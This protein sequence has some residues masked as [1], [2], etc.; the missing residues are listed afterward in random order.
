MIST[1]REDAERRSE[2]CH[3][4]SALYLSPHCAQVN[5]LGW[6]RSRLKVLL[7]GVA[8]KG[9]RFTLTVESVETVEGI[10]EL[11]PRSGCQAGVRSA[12]GE[13]GAK[14]AILR[15]L[16]VSI[17]LLFR[18]AWIGYLGA[19]ELRGSCELAE[20]D[21]TADFGF[22]K[23][24]FGDILRNPKEEYRKLLAQV[25]NEEDAVHIREH[26][27]AKGLQAELA[28]V[29]GRLYCDEWVGMRE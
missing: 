26:C 16:C 24:A 19:H 17:Q 3:L 29:L 5:K 9:E 23:V 28:V 7:P 27:L 12:A 18:V 15:P 11:R 14:E 8:H 25:I 6:L 10:A 22:R 2:S 20:W 13:P 1:L 4:Y 21:G